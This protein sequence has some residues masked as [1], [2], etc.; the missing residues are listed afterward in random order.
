MYEITIKATDDEGLYDEL[1]VT[2]IVTD[3]NEPPEFSGATTSRDVSENTA[4]NQN[5]GSPVSA[6]DPERDLLT[7]S[8]SGSDAQ[9][10][11]IAT[12]TG[13]ILTKSTDLDYESSRRRA[14]R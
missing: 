12:S 4:P 2:V 7:Y 13:Q 3:E 8:I 11:D 10:F 5:V 6:T 14:T 9:F 1:E